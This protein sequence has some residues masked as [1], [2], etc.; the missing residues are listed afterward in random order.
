MIA[1]SGQIQ[2]LKLLETAADYTTTE[3]LIGSDSENDPISLHLNGPIIGFY[4]SYLLELDGLNFY[5]DTT[6]CYRSQINAFN[7]PDSTTLLG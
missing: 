7:L 2:G 5:V 3:H 6:Y 1:G 4:G